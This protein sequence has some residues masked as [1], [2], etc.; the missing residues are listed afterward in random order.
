MAPGH[1]IDMIIHLASKI[2]RILCGNSM[3]TNLGHCGLLYGL[4]R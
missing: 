3:A 4:L 1:L 2:I